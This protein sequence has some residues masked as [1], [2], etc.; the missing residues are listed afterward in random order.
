MFPRAGM[1]FILLSLGHVVL[2]GG[3]YHGELNE[4]GTGTLRS[5]RYR[6]RF[7]QPQNS[8]LLSIVAS[9]TSSHRAL[10]AVS[11]DR[12]RCRASRSCR[13]RVPLVETSSPGSPFARPEN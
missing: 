8:V 10:P 4:R 6:V 5:Q 9:S 11:R 13:V 1:P 3:H 7:T 2:C 12:K